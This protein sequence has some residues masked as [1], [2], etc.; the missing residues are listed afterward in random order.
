[1]RNLA[2]CVITLGTVQLVIAAQAPEKPRVFVSESGSCDT[3][4]G[5]WGPT[6]RAGGWSFGSANG[7]APFQAAEIIRTLREKC[8][9]VT[10]TMK[11]HRADYVILLDHES[12]RTSLDKRLSLFNKDCDSIKSGSTGSLSSSVESVCIALMEDL[13][14]HPAEAAPATEEQPH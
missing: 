14:T 8:R 7:G 13:K 12:S 5:S 1:V 6:R 9:G 2:A 4:G 11:R 10:V 3:S